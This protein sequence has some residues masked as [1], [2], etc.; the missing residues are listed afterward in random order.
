MALG[1]ER[2]L[3]P[4]QPRRFETDAQLLQLG[5]QGV[6][7]RRRLGE[8]GEFDVGAQEAAAGSPRSSSQS[9]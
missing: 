6:G 1:E 7:V 2:R 3:D 5:L 9:A 8:L 4:P